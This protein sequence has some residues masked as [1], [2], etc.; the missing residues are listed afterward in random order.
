MNKMKVAILAVLS[1][2]IL[3]A[4]GGSG[5]YKTN[6]IAGTET[7]KQGDPE[8]LVYFYMPTCSH[9]QEFKPTLE[10]YI[11]KDDALPMYK[12]NLALPAEKESW[13][14]YDVQGTPTLLHIED[15]NG[16]KVEIDRLLGVQKLA[17][18][19]VSESN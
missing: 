5:F 17:D 8:Y 6:A 3:S 4:C 9:C 13:A 14:N 19:P 10:E 1:V 11:T 16:D 15:R 2:L 18:I 12:V 7:Y